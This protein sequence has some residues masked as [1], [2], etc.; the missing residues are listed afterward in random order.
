MTGLT[1][2]NCVDD[3]YSEDFIVNN[4]F[5]M[6]HKQLVI[7]LAGSQSDYQH[8]EK[9]KHHINKQGMYTL[10]Y[11]S[12]AHKNTRQVL[13]ILEKFENSNRQIIYVT[14]AGRSNALS[15]V[16]SCNT[17]YPVIACPPFKDKMDMATNINST[18]QCPSKVPVLTILEPENVSIAI[19]KIFSLSNF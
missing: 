5:K 16:V 3:L 2:E 19:K 11:V 14:V 1:V 6:V 12:S 15:G 13:S 8:I 4:Y 9:L 17:Q 18:L 10:V 7:I